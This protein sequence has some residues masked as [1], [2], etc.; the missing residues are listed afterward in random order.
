VGAV[1]RRVAIFY[2]RF[3]AEL[4]RYAEGVHNLGEPARADALL[5]L[6]D[7]L[8]SFLRS[9][10]GAELFI[11]AVTILPVAGITREEDLVVFG[12]TGAG[13]R[14]ALDGKGRVLRLE[15][16]TGERLVE[17]TSFAR[18]LE[19]FVAG[20]GILYDREGEFQEVFDD[21][22]ELLPRFAEKRER[23]VLKVDPG[24]S[25]P[26][27]RLAKALAKLGHADKA[28]AALREAVELDPAFG[29]AWFDLGQLAR[30]AGDL[31]EAEA[32][33]ARA[34]EAEPE[35]EHAGYFAAHAARIAR[36]RGDEPGRAKHAGRALTLEPDLARAQKEA[37][38]QLLLE[39]R[40]DEA[41]EAA[42]IAAALAPR[43]LEALD[44]LKKLS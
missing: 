44:L 11:D 24:A 6:P 23:K 1:R 42:A 15:E 22:G 36:D 38:R 4:A 25:A 29:W 9:W 12:A 16:D 18:W 33:Y 3:R 20:E 28:I 10:D 26:R 37:A 2:E 5:G 40:V 41:R 34:A 19:A 7:E 17:G 31:D 35:Y 27:W 13:D 39:E 30:A 32:A 8:G 21:E 43:D 14:L